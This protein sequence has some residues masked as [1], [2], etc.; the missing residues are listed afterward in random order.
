MTGTLNGIFRIVNEYDNDARPC[1]SCA[2]RGAPELF[3]DQEPA[4]IARNEKG[5]DFS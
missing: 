4:N 1:D 3:E 5:A 2:L